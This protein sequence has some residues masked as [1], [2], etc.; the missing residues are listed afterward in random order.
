ML[1]GSAVVF[2]GMLAMNGS[3]PPARE[4]RAQSPVS[5]AVKRQRRPKP[6]REN[7]R[8]PPPRPRARAP[9]APIPQLAVSLSGVSFGIPPIGSTKLDGAAEE[10]LGD[11]ETALEDVVMNE[12]AVDVAPQAVSRRAPAYPPRARAEGVT[13]KVLLRLLIGLDGRVIEAEVVESAPQG[14]FD[15][16]ARAAVREWRFAPAQYRGQPVKVWARQ[17]LSFELG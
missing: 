1:F 7:V 13:G 15:E 17:R 3:R 5:F 6:R 11:A 14:V 16:A 8:R 2:G 10:L 9:R 12:H 4:D